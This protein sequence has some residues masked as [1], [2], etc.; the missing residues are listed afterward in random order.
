MAIIMVIIQFSP[1]RASRER[2]NELQVASC[3]SR[4]VSC[5]S[6]RA[7]GCSEARNESGLF[8]GVMRGRRGEASR[9][10]GRGETSEAKIAERSLS[11]PPAIEIPACRLS[12]KD[13]ILNRIAELKCSLKSCMAN[14]VF[15]LVPPCAFPA[16]R[17]IARPRMRLLLLSAL[18]WFSGG[19]L[20]V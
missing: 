18:V 9:D 17:A 13:G 8:V 3:K 10:E 4:A 12:S 19:A 20:I 14:L 1:K 2:A 6:Q 16:M 11:H 5:N 15:N 7:W